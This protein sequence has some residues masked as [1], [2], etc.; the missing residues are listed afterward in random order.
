MRIPTIIA[1]L[2]AL[3][4]TAAWATNPWL[5]ADRC[6][7]F[8]VTGT[9]IDVGSVCANSYDYSAKDQFFRNMVANQLSS[10][11]A[12]MGCNFSRG[13][14]FDGTYTENDPTFVGQP[15][16]KAA[17]W[18]LNGEQDFSYCNFNNNPPTNAIQDL[19]RQ[20]VDV[21]LLI[22]VAFRYKSNAVSPQALMGTSDDVSVPGWRLQFG[23]GGDAIFQRN[24]GTFASAVEMLPNGTM[25]D[26]TDYL[27]VFYYESLSRGWQLFLNSSSFT[28]GTMTNLPSSIYTTSGIFT[29]GAANNNAIATT[30]DINLIMADGTLFYG[31][32]ILTNPD[33]S[34]DINTD[35]I[36]PYE[37]RYGINFV[38]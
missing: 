38:P 23:T 28:T 35:I 8:T 22:I 36:D 13:P 30:K 24:S 26:N 29:V 32:T 17:H 3:I 21:N 5:A 1:A 6:A 25:I 12:L 2:I 15:G 19:Q 31:W 16:T 27:L 10:A 14:T 33:P 18:H 34:L 7:P 4:P 20:D 11:S 37:S 9:T